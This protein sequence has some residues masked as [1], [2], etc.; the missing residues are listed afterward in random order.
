MFAPNYIYKTTFLLQTTYIYS[1]NFK[2]VKL[3]NRF[4]IFLATSFS[5]GSPTPLSSNHLTTY[6]LQKLL[7]ATNTKPAATLNLLNS[8]T[9]SERSDSSSI[10][11]HEQRKA[12][13][14]RIF[15]DETGGGAS[16]VYGQ[17]AAQQKL[18]EVP[19]RR[20]LDEAKEQIDVIDFTQPKFRYV[21]VLGINGSKIHFVP[22]EHCIYSTLINA[23]KQCQCHLC[24]SNVVVKYLP[25]L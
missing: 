16:I 8:A 1:G 7:S 21:Y 20:Y 14:E 13:E 22:H 25:C 10:Y 18:H 3:S 2:S 5:T 9:A 17:P 4:W 24:R 15:S 19:I 23:K 11:G 6:I 12:A